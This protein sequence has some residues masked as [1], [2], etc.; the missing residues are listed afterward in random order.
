MTLFGAWRSRRALEAVAAASALVLVASA[1]NV[2]RALV[3][4]ADGGGALIPNAD[5]VGRCGAEVLL[6][7]DDT[8]PAGVAAEAG[9]ALGAAV[10]GSGSS[11]AVVS[12]GAA[13]RPVGPG[14]VEVTAEALV[15]GGPLDQVLVELDGLGGATGARDRTGA[16]AQALDTAA[17]AGASPLLIAYLTDGP[18]PVDATTTAAA[19]ALRSRPGTHLVFL[20]AGE[21]AVAPDDLVALAGPDVVA[22]GGRLLDVA[23]DDVV[24][25]PDAASLPAAAAELG[26]GLCATRVVVEAL[27]SAAEPPAP[28]AGHA[29]GLEVVDGATPVEGVAPVGPQATD[30]SG[31]AAWRVA[32]SPGST[33]T[34]AVVDPG[35]ASGTRALTC[36][37]ADGLLTT[38]GGERLVLDGVPAG[39]EVSCQLRLLDEAKPL[40]LRLVPL[41]G[42]VACPED[43]AGLRSLTAASIGSLVTYCVEL[44][45]EGRRTA[46]GV[47]LDVPGIDP[48][49]GTLVMATELPPAARTRQRYVTTL[50]GPAPVGAVATAQGMPADEAGAFVGVVP[51]A[52]SVERLEAGD[53][54]CGVPEETPRGCYRAANTGGSWLDQLNLVPAHT[55]GAVSSERRIAPGE[56]VV[57]VPPPV[58]GQPSAP[59]TEPTGEVAIQPMP[60]PLADAV[61]TARAVDAAGL[62]L[63]GA[64]PVSSATPAGAPVLLDPIVSDEVVPKGDVVD[65]GLT[66]SNP[67]GAATLSNVAMTDTACAEAGTASE[68][69]GNG[70][71]A[72]D[73]GETWLMACSAPVEVEVLSVAAFSATFA[74]DTTTTSTV[75][76]AVN[77]DKPVTPT[78]PDLRIKKSQVGDL[79]PGSATTYE[80]K[81]QNTGRFPAT[82]VVVSDPLPAGLVFLGASADAGT[83]SPNGNQVTCNIGTLTPQEST[84][85][86]MVRITVQASAPLTDQVVRN[87]ASV[88]A[89]EADVDVSDNVSWVRGKVGVCVRN[90][91]DVTSVGG[92]DPADEGRSDGTV[93]VG[94]EQLAR[95]GVDTV[96]ASA[97]GLVLLASGMSLVATARRR[98]ALLAIA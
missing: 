13:T 27:D 4:E 54:R 42:D 57:L 65:F 34:L 46:V 64:E 35:A 75:E 48:A 60:A 24:L 2:G 81:V 39:A 85:H 61:G 58:E 17:G 14:F 86:V 10:E 51:P 28:L 97:W 88:S 21:A 26:E 9:R 55:D 93:S 92:P 22:A 94:G 41:P 96:A 95:T 3:A 33:T 29:L 43:L 62:A 84:E 67:V 70:D 71:A 53:P 79:M 45:N 7:A 52:L 76:Q 12:A 68:L 5:L 50:Q 72:L 69:V 38:G 1:V 18:A 74:Q 8:L 19:E 6:V 63:A 30:D 66:V 87:E 56:A 15:S 32:M 59:S 47:Q 31:R 82:G 37:G 20:A 44:V 49:A 11:L 89:N 77:R 23:R 98:W 73:G 36:V 78:S 25:V 80:L 83:C 91:P 40:R 16:L 90:C